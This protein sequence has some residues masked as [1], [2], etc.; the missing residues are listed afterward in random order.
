MKHDIL[1]SMD[2]G[3]WYAYETLVALSGFSFSGVTRACLELIEDG[4]LEGEIFNHKKRVRLAMSRPKSLP[5]RYG[6]VPTVA[7]SRFVPQW[8][9]LKSYDSYT[10]GLKALCEVT[11]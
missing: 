5:R 6:C 4:V 8:S 3:V 10:H 7:T 2:L 11:R 9:P 1:E